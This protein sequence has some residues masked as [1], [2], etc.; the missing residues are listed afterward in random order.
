MD[1]REGGRARLGK[2]VTGITFDRV[3]TDSV[4]YALDGD[5]PADTSETAFILT[6]GPLIPAGHSSQQRRSPSLTA[7]HRSGG[8]PR[9]GR[10]A[11]GPAGNLACAPIHAQ[12]TVAPWP[13]LQ[14]A[15]SS[16]PVVL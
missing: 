13:P 15:V 4:T 5:Y 6:L 7:D 3:T 10:S 16:H 2:T 12:Q 11:P 1:D 14:T 8:G 9:A